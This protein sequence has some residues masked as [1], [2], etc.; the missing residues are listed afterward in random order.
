MIKPALW[1]TPQVS[2]GGGRGGFSGVMMVVVADDGVE[3]MT[4]HFIV[5]LQYVHWVEILMKFRCSLS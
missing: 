2:L 4:L 5:N 3:L 1:N